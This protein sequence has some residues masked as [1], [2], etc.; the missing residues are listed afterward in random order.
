MKENKI[1]EDD[2]QED[3]ERKQLYA[4]LCAHKK[5]YFFAYNYPSLKIEYDAFVK[6][7]NS[8]AVSLYKKGL[9]EFVEQYNNGELFEEDE[10]KFI[11][12]FQR[13]LPLDRSPGTMNRIC[14]A[15]EKAFDGVDLFADV[16]FD[17]ALLKFGVKYDQT[18]YEVIKHI[19]ATYKPS[20]QLAKKRAILHS[21]IEEDNDWTSVD[22]IMQDLI[23]QL[24]ANCSNEQE[25]CDILA[26]LCYQDGMPKQIFWMACGDTIICKLLRE[27]NFTM[28]YPKRSDNGE[29]ACQ[30]IQ[31]V[32]AEVQVKGGETDEG[33]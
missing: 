28:S 6:N 24:Y 10:I 17:S 30:G 5:P 2:T 23:E 27:H 9:E 21:D 22:M 18:L 16:E 33:I 1:N 13:K 4:K 29:F 26:D 25:L 14:W 19:C 32:M 31:Y 3:I 8:N 15:I 7:A 11:E 12:N 20:V